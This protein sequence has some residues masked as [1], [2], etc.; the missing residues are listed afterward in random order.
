MQDTI[1]QFIKDYKWQ[2]AL[3]ALG[4]LIGGGFLFFGKGDSTGTNVAALV[5]T[6]ESA[7]TDLPAGAETS[8]SSAQ[9]EATGT[10]WVDVKGAVSSP[11]LYE[12]PGDARVDDAIAVAGGL[13]T[14]ADENSV[15]RAQKLADEAVVYVAAE[16]EDISVVT[17]T[18]SA[19]E[20]DSE[21][22]TSS[23]LVNLNTATAAEL[24]TIT[25]I[26]EKRAADIIAYREANGLFNS[27]DDLK[28]VSGIGDKTLENIRPYVTVD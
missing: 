21:N 6:S 1:L 7:S 18:T 12:L 28:N 26:G 27:V 17:S 15:N 3:V 25:G 10:I 16:G 4:A 5:A 11:G 13:T 23:A 22:S 14:E 2:V 20:T 19:V 9:A 8:E 24:Q